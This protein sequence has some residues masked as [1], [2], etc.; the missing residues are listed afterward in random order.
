MTTTDAIHLLR[1]FPIALCVWREARGEPP[2]GKLLVA[3]TIEN[4]VQDSRWP[5]TYVSVITQ[6]WQFSAFNKN[7]PNVTA[8][9]KERDPAWADCV[10]A[11]EYVLASP[12]PLTRANHYHATSLL[13]SWA[14]RADG[15][16]RIEA[17]V[18][19]EGN[20]V[21]YRL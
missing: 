1:V 20:H 21:F 6:P 8:Y 12:T 9:P 10:A 18:N 2:L 17:I 15:T 14:K 16:Q 11:A 4:R 7:D 3:Q 19:R 13:P 5:D